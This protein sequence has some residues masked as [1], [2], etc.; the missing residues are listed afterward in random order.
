MVGLKYFLAP[1]IAKVNNVFLTA[2]GGDSYVGSPV[3][4][5]R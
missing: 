3:L 2:P 4:G 5:Y 1:C